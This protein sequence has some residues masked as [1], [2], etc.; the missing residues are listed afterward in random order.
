MRDDTALA[1]P[2]LLELRHIR[3][4]FGG[5]AAL[6]DVDFTLHAGEVHGLVGENGAGKS[7]MMKIIAGVHAADEGTMRLGGSLVRFRSARDARDAGI[8]MVHQELSIVPEL[9]VAENIALG[10]QPV[11]RIGLVSWRRMT[12]E[13]RGH[14]TRLGIDI[15]PTVPAGS[16]PLGLQ[17]MVE[18]ARVLSSAPGS[19][20]STSRP[21][22]SRRPRSSGCS[23]C[24]AASARL[25]PASCSSATFS[26][27][28]CGSAT[29]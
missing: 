5:V 23:P 25:A 8:G 28:C 6:T 13:A 10:T 21:R 9:S 2:P 22:H 20:F 16:L 18:L 27:T 15:D 19:S 14:L 26:T 17:Q 29:R 12:Q 24:C 1:E 11:N 7:T 4:S 3:K